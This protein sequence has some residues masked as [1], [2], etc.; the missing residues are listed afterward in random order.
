[1]TDVVRFSAICR[2]L[3]AL[4]SLLEHLES[5]VTSAADCNNLFCLHKINLDTQLFHKGKKPTQDNFHL[6]TVC[7]SIA[8]WKIVTNFNTITLKCCK[9]Q[10]LEKQI[11]FGS[12][13]SAVNPSIWRSWGVMM[14][15][16][17][18]QSDGYARSRVDSELCM[19]KD[20]CDYLKMSIFLIPSNCWG[21]W[22]WKVPTFSRRWSNLLSCHNGVYTLLGFAYTLCLFF[23][24]AFWFGCRDWIGQMTLI[25]IVLTYFNLNIHKVTKASGME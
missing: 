25:P 19:R 6:H 14:D 18:D 1:M 5:L 15:V 22:H 4:T 16:S 3:K 8:P 20:A 7:L 24:V 23:V 17:P 13:D 9:M 11:V 12:F 10:F 2:I 21:R